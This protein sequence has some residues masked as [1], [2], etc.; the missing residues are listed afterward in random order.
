MFPN[1]AHFINRQ[2]ILNIR[3]SKINIGNDLLLIVTCKYV[4]YTMTST[5]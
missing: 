2:R 5:M 1:E 4:A 3:Y